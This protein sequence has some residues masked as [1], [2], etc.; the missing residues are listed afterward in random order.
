MQ[1]APIT[2]RV[3]NQPNG[4][5]LVQTTAGTLTPNLRLNPAL[6]LACQMLASLPKGIKVHYWHDED[7]AV[8]LVRQLLNPE[9]FGYSVT[10]EVRRAA[11]DVLGITLRNWNPA[12]AGEES[13]A[14]GTL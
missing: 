5:I 7:K 2:I 1:H 14:Y 9:G 11:A 3:S 6:S 10:H 8:E 4:D 13:Q 12:Q